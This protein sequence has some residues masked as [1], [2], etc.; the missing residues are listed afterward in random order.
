V[1]P[2]VPLLTEDGVLGQPPGPRL[3]SCGV[4][5]HEITIHRGDEQPESIRQRQR[6]VT[7]PAGRASDRPTLPP[8]LALQPAF[9]LERGGVR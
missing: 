1:R 2:V 4:H 8:S 3:F 9:R 7:A 5:G 6:R